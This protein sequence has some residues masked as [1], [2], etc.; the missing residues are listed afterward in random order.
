MCVGVLQGRSDG[1][2]V[3]DSFGVDGGGGRERVGL[4]WIFGLGGEVVSVE[5]GR[6]FCVYEG[7]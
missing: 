4:G 3:V 5:V 7:K 1:Y 6:C 2:W